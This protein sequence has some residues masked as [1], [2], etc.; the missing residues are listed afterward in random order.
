LRFEASGLPPLNIN[1]NPNLNRD[2][3]KKILGKGR[4]ENKVAKKN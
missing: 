2:Q 3:G 4:G 1:S